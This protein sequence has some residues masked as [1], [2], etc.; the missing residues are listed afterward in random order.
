MFQ[1]HSKVKK[2]LKDW[3]SPNYNWKVF[4]KSVLNHMA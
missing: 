3:E 4:S 1:F 2:R